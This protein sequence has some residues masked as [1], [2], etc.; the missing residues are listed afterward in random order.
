MKRLGVSSVNAIVSDGTVCNNEFIE[1]FDKVLV[2]APCSG[3]GVISK[4][5]DIKWAEKNYE[6]L[7]KIQCKILD[8]ASQYLKYGGKMVY[9]TCTVNSVENE[10]V[11]DEFLN[12]HKEFKLIDEPLQL[13]PCEENDGFFMCSFERVINE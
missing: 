12:K 9:S 3:L 10:K 2:D 4:K 13:F 8:N 11:V 6:E 5:P 1:A 7:H